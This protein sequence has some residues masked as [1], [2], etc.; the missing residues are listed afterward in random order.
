MMLRRSTGKH[1]R[2]SSIV[3]GPAACGAPAPAQASPPVAAAVTAD[4][5][6]QPFATAPAQAQTGADSEQAS[7]GPAAS[8]ALDCDASPSSAAYKRVLALPTR[9]FRA[10]TSTWPP[11]Q[12]AQ[13]HLHRRQQ[14]NKV[15]A[16]RKREKAREIK[17]LAQELRQENEGPHGTAAGESVPT[18]ILRL[19]LVQFRQTIATWDPEHQ[20]KAHVMRRQLQNREA[21]RTLRRK[22]A[23]AARATAESQARVPHD[24]GAG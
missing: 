8:T 21:A 20:R 7:P 16:S 1:T 5:S 18:S 9:E 11:R 17:K 2:S 22:S 6:E 12:R 15:A 3:I 19:E 10:T 24:A 4:I 13:V 23:I 14:Q